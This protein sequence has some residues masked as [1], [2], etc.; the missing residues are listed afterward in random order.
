M[1]DIDT[2]SVKSFTLK[3]IPWASEIHHNLPSY[4]KLLHKS[5]CEFLLLLLASW[6]SEKT[7]IRDFYQTKFEI[8]EEFL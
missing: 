1:A 6:W 3:I 8:V 7:V 4:R 2:K 5:Y